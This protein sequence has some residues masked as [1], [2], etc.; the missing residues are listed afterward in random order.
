MNHQGDRADL[1]RATPPADADE[2]RRW[3]LLVRLD[4]VLE[5]DSDWSSRLQELAE[6]IAAELGDAVLVAARRP[7]GAGRTTALAH[8]DQDRS[9]RWHAAA[10]DLADADLAAAA[11]WL[12]QH[13]RTIATLRVADAPAGLS[14]TLR[15]Y[16][17]EVGIADAALA[18]ISFHGTLVGLL[19][20]VRDADSSTYPPQDLVGLRAAATR[21][22]LLLGID[23]LGSERTRSVR[24]WDAVFAMSPVGICTVDAAGLISG[25]NPSALAILDRPAG[26]V[27]GSVPEQLF[28]PALTSGDAAGPVGD[29][30]MGVVTN[31]VMGPDGEPHWWRIVTTPIPEAD[32]PSTA[33][34]VMFSDMS[35]WFRAEERAA[36][37][38]SLVRSSPDFIAIADLDGR[39]TFVNDAGRRL[40]G[41][42]DDV[43]LTNLRAAQLWSTETDAAAEP[44]RPADSPAGHGWWHGLSTLRPWD[45]GT[46]IPV[47]ATTFVV[48][49]PQT[50]LP[51]AVATKRR[52]VRD[53]LESQR[54][55]EALAEQ[56]RALLRDLVDTEHNERSRLAEYL[57]DEPVQLVAAAQLRLQ[58]L[59]LQGESGDADGVRDSTRNLAELLDRAQHCL[60]HIMSDIQPEDDPTGN[61]ADQLRETARVL[62]AGSRTEV[63]V[64]GEVG[65]L[66]ADVAAAL[67]R[68]AREA[69][70]NARKHARASQIR[71]LLESD[72]S[73]HCVV[74]EDNGIGVGDGVRERKGHLGVRLITTRMRALGG[75]VTF[76][77]RPGGGTVVTLSVPLPVR[78]L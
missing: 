13:G 54:N 34:V 73:G 7:D 28:S 31:R 49:D 27:I 15:R 29:V 23:R 48:P 65:A 59:Q 37:F 14:E 22:G 41:L 71:V 52:D 8:P 62:F 78:E 39:V 42:P 40:V 9:A 55:L 36:V 6:V 26:D 57:H 10:A 75:D 38:E 66:P 1:A 74:V 5:A 35:D 51:A 44:D 43:E 58:L 33:Q 25:A 3:R 18:A 72:E 64:E 12:A 20:C 77:E 68:S 2:S 47:L 69:L 67:R 53:Q 70:N 32:D 63:S 45:G 19:V 16:D 50:G 4:D 61:M 46:E 17:A 24:R 60:R 76:E 11:E 56:R 30:P 21:A